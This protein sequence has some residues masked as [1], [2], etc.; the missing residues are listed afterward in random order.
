MPRPRSRRWLGGRAGDRSGGG[1]EHG[2]RLWLAWRCWGEGMEERAGSGPRCLRAGAGCPA[3][4]PAPGGPE[5]GP[6]RADASPFSPQLSAT[7]RPTWRW[8]SRGGCSRKTCTCRR[9]PA[10]QG[11]A[12]AGAPARPQPS[13]A[14]GPAS[15]PCCCTCRPLGATCTCSCAVTCASCPAAS[16]WRRPAQPG[17]ADAPQS[18]ASTLAACSATPAL[19]SRLAPAAPPV[20]WYCPLP[21]RV[22]LAICRGAEGGGEGWFPGRAGIGVGPPACSAAGG[23]EHPQPS[24][25]SMSRE[26]ERGSDLLSSTF[27]W[28]S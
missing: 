8:C 16:R 2:R 12:G 23:R 1:A 9:C 7:R 28:P 26:L 3:L 22:C 18:C 10:L 19:S 27:H 11:P 24:R 14:P 6:R 15:A 4:D 20:A 5:G 21:L 17:A 25:G 13:R